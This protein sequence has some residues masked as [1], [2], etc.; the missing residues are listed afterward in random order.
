L[1]S[2]RRQ[3]L[4]LSAQIDRVLAGDPCK[5]RPMLGDGGH[6]A[7]AEE[8]DAARRLGQMV[9]RLPPVPAELERRVSALVHTRLVGEPHLLRHSM[10]RRRWQPAV[11][12][13][14]ATAAVLIALWVVLP[15]A[16]PGVVAQM[17]AVLLGQTRVEVTPTLAVGA[18]P[19]RE[20]VRD[21]LAAELLIGRAPSL[22]KT[23]PDG[24]TLQEVAAISYADLPAWISQP[25]CVELCYGDVSKPCALRLRQYRLL[26]RDFGGISGVKVASDAVRDVEQVDLNGATGMRFALDPERDQGPPTHAVVW[27]RDGLLLELESEQLTADQ[28]LEIARSTR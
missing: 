22:P 18:E 21:L 14:L 12:S 15:S 4:A 26:F 19:I 2:E 6:K 17:R 20:P 10:Q 13:A 28:L 25:L 7:A 1:V 23:L 11:W 16:S 27:E 24:Y 5:Q 9:G 3:A 8:L